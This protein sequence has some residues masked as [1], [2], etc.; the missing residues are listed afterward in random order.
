ME[1]G[2]RDAMRC[3]AKYSTSR[4]LFSQPESGDMNIKFSYTWVVVKTKM[5]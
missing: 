4:S 2:D 5:K 3:Q 1:P